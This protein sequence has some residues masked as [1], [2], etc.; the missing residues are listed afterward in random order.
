MSTKILITG[1]TGFVGKQLIKILSSHNLEITLIVR[2]GMEEQ[3]HSISNTI[4]FITTKDLFKETQEWWI[5]Q[6]QGI[7]TIVHLAWYVEPKLYLDSKKNLE[8]LTGSL[9]LAKA[10]VLAGVKR[11][12]GVGTCFEYDLSKGLLSVETPLKP[13]TLYAGTKAALFFSLLHWFGIHK[14]EFAWCRLFYLFGEG[15]N[16]DRL[17]PYI[18]SK[19]KNGEVAE[20]TS[21]QQ[22]R[23]FLDVA[24]AA[25]KLANII[26]S[27]QVGPINICSGIPITVRQFAEKIADEYGRR[28]LLKFNSRPDNLFDPNYILGVPNIL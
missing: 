20:L 26:L 9:C 1:C 13:V 12:I 4:R 17:V 16:S 14:V 18:R 24:V 19:M 28:D 6:C 21:G 2:E 8:C 15:E 27:K 11:F 23:D 3:I 10:S 7:D 22:T 25:K 5:K